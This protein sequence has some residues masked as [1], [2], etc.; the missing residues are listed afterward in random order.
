MN[1][2]TSLLVMGVGWFS[3]PLGGVGEL[4]MPGAGMDTTQHVES[5][6]EVPLGSGVL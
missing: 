1:V 5:L 6:C 3:R 4:A 2:K